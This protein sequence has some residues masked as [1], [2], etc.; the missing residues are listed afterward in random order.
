[1]SDYRIAPAATAALAQANLLWPDRDKT[2]DGTLGDYAHSTRKSW[3]NP[4]DKNGNKVPGGTVCAFDLTN[5]P[6][7]GCDA[8]ALV[9]AAVARGERRINEAISRGRIWTRDRASEGWRPYKG[10]NPH[11]HHAHVSVSWEYRTETAPW[12]ITEGDDDMTPEQAA[13]LAR[14]E[15]KLDALIAPRLPG[16]KDRDP[17]HVDLADVLNDDGD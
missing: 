6:A 5:D 11:N 3:H 16:G 14:I 2:F 8:H 13:Q 9:R 10:E 7:H 17:H 1:M 4:C 15:A 12:W